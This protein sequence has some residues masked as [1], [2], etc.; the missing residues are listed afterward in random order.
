MDYSNESSGGELLYDLRQSYVVIVTKNL[1]LINLY[2]IDNNYSKCYELILD[3]F[4]M[5]FGRTTKDRQVIKEKF[6]NLVD[7][8]NKLFSANILVYSGKSFD[9]QTRVKIKDNLRELLFFLYR[10]LDQ[11]GHFGM[12]RVTPN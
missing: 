12:G 1:E 9:S 5:V 6:N 7:S 3:T 8:S 11:A 4:P 2:L 10:T